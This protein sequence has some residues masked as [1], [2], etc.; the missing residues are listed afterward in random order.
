MLA[1]PLSARPLSLPLSVR[2]DGAPGWR[3]EQAIR[4]VAAAVDRGTTGVL[5]GARTAGYLSG[6]AF[7]LRQSFGWWLYD[8]AMPA[9]VR[10]A[11]GA[12]SAE[13]YAGWVRHAR[14]ILVDPAEW[15][16]YRRAC[17]QCLAAVLAALA[18]PGAE[19]RPLELP[20]STGLIGFRR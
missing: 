2:L 9:D 8:P 20:A 17:P 3:E 12:W 13:E 15:P 18:A 4:A 11:N 5:V 6:L 19:W 1:G 7:P 10:R 16:D 14:V